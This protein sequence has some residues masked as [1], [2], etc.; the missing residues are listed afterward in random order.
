MNGEPARARLVKQRGQVV[1][2]ALWEQPAY[3]YEGVKRPARRLLLASTGTTGLWALNPENGA[4]VWQRKLPDGGVSRPVAVA[5]A[6]LINASQLGTYLLSPVDGSLIDG[7]HFDTG[8]A[9]T[10]AAFGHH[11]FVMTNSGTLL[12]FRVAVPSAHIATPPNVH[13]PLDGF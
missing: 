11:A 10:P 7:I 6:I 9:G 4:R 3:V 8:I 2:V 12:A 5:G 13:G 1:Y